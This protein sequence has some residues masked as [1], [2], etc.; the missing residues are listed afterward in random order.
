MYPFNIVLAGCAADLLPTLRSEF[1][2]RNASIKVELPRLDQLA[3]VR[4]SDA[5][6]RMLFVVQIRGSSDL[7]HVKRLK[8]QFVGQPVLVLIDANAPSSLLLAAMRVGASQVVTLPLERSDLAAALEGLHIQQLGL[9][10]SQGRLIAVSGVNGGC[11]GTTIALNL[12]A[13]LSEHPQTN[14]ILTELTM[15]VGMLVTHLDVEP[16]YTL[17]DLLRY[18]SEL[19]LEVVAQALAP[20]TE[21]FKV[22]LGPSHAFRA[23][24]SQ[25]A[26]VARIL[27]LLRFLADVVVVDIPWTFDDHYLEILSAADQVIL[28]AEQRI[29]SIRNLQLVLDGLGV[30]RASECIVVLNRY[31]P[32]MRGFTTTEL[33]ELVKMS[34][35]V[36]VRNDPKIPEALNNG[37]ALHVHAVDASALDDLE[38][39]QRLLTAGEGSEKPAPAPRRPRRSISRSIFQAIGL[40]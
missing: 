38:A 23:S 29:P 2:N 18:G 4:P 22:L 28:V 6:E 25:Q 26:G 5:S 39:L 34:R 15:P 20:I 13:Q 8:T 3:K 32:Q 33:T 36:T 17:A 1:S 21:R 7:E 14:T 35:V 40:A 31:D 37:R 27:H 16:K 12:A 9:P 11:G 24:E 10:Q 19:D 30:N